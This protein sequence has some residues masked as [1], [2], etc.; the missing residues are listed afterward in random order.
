MKKTTQIIFY[1]M[2]VC[3]LSSCD[4]KNLAKRYTNRSKASMF[5]LAAT[6]QTFVQVGLKS[7]IISDPSKIPVKYNVLS[8]SE[9][10]QEAYIANA[11]ALITNRTAYLE[12]IN[13][14][15]N[16]SE[17][18]KPN[19]KIIPKI[20]KKAFI[21]EVDKLQY[22]YVKPGESF[23]SGKTIFNIPGDRI[24]Y[25]ELELKLSDNA[26]IIFNSWDTYSSRYLTQNLGHVTASQNWNA[27]L[28][29]SANAGGQ[30]A[31]NTGNT[32]EGFDSNKD[33][34]GATFVNTGAASS[35]TTSNGYELISSDKGTKTNSKG[36]T[37]SVGLGVSGT[38]GY[39][40]NYETSTD[41][42]SRRLEL[43]G[44][45]GEHRMA[46]RQEGGNL[47]DLSGNVEVTV[48]LLVTDDWAPPINLFKFKGL[49]N[50]GVVIAPNL[51]KKNMMTILF[52]DIK[53][54][55]IGTLDYSFLYRQ[56]TTG[57][58][59]I[60]E[61]RQKI[62]FWHGFVESSNNLKLKTEPAVLLKK[63]DLRPKIYELRIGTQTLMYDNILLRFETV[64]EATTFLR[65][66]GDL[67]LSNVAISNI[68]ID[69]QVLSSSSFNAIKIATVQL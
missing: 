46:I 33:T 21:F 14:G 59:H 41:L 51:I 48:E 2:A 52:P 30:V 27:S 40:N 64:D 37:G 3:L 63:E 56:V 23:N 39:Q 25:L 34:S 28:T 12:M 15:F 1:I 16:L 29:A 36:I 66:I 7:K 45:L 67:I 55:I 65:Y 18:S 69:S 42:L 11:R 49:Y 47:I 54:D 17:E 57:H 26:N 31:F 62:H 68:S 58:R 44:V 13:S 5:S 35:D 53:N 6:P 10:G 50:A 38:V 43:T 61:A 60:P 22:Q 4:S 8:L 32:K 9:R 24:A 19:I 20:V